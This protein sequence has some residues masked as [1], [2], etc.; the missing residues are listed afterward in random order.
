M[1]FVLKAPIFAGDR[2]RVSALGASRC[3]RLAGKM[4]TV[5]GGSVYAS[6]FQVRFDGNKC[7]STLHRDYLEVL[8]HVDP[9]E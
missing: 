5:V 4:G 7:A 3:A 6:S 2:V 1:F 9:A 8:T